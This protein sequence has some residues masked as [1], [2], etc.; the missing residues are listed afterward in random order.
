MAGEF[1]GYR[2]A[3]HIFSGNHQ[4]AADRFMSDGSHA[5]IQHLFMNGRPSDISRRV[6]AIAVNA[7]KHV[8]RSRFKSYARKELLER[9]KLKLNPSATVN[10]PAFF[11]VRISTA[12]FG[13]EISPS[14]WGH[15]RPARPSMSVSAHHMIIQENYGVF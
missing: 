14:F 3:G 7:V 2:I 1:V 4:I 10:I 5:A 8:L 15:R 11:V 13:V 12:R 6:V 9:L